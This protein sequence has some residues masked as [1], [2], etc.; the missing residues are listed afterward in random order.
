MSSWWQEVARR[1]RT[2][3]ALADL[4]LPAGALVA[5]LALG[6]VVVLVPPLW[7]LLRVAVTVVHELGHG[8]VGILVGRSFTGL[9]LRADMSG[10]AVTVGPQHGPGRVVTTWAGYPA[11][12]VVG[13]V[14]VWSATRGWAAPVLGGLT[15]ILVVSLVRVRSWYTL[16]VMLAA[17]G[18]VGWLWWAGAP[19]AQGLALVATGVLLTLGA[20]RHLAAVVR[21]PSRGSDP[22]VLARLTPLPAVGWNLSFVVVLGAASWLVAR[23]LAPLVVG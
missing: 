17:T 23:L 16:L 22:G 12:A 7:R 2:D 5:A 9:V 13:L 3:A 15:V 6:A 1:W 21:G 10:H 18:G 11:P 19:A 8:V 4:D 14:L 20:W